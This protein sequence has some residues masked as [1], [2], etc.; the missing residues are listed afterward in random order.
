MNDNAFVTRHVSNPVDCAGHAQR[1]YAE[2]GRR[3]KAN[4]F[5]VLITDTMLV[6][7]PQQA[8]LAWTALPHHSLRSRRCWGLRAVNEHVDVVVVGAGIIGLT[9][10]LELLEQSRDVSVAITDKV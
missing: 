3:T 4:Q 9:V 2:E 10:A 5:L 1:V 8:R 7:H 6:H